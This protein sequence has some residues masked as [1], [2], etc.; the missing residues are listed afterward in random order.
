MYRNTF[1]KS[2]D[3]MITDLE[4]LLASDPLPVQQSS[5]SPQ[6]KGQAITE[7]QSRGL[8]FEQVRQPP[9]PAKPEHVPKKRSGEQPRNGVQVGDK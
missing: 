8:N 3:E 5:P 7:P 1:S 6:I 2:L 9:E 4:A